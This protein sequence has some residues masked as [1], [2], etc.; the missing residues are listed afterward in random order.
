M[1]REGGLTIDRESEEEGAEREWKLLA[2][3]SSTTGRTN[4]TKTAKADTSITCSNTSAV[5]FHTH[6]FIID[7]P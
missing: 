6:D 4:G 2:G 5:A 1:K 7:A 3:L